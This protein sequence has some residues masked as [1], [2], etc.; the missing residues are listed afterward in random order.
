MGN[1]GD[2]APRITNRETSDKRIA[3]SGRKPFYDPASPV[4]FRSLQQMRYERIL[5]ANT[6]IHGR[7]TIE[8][9]IR[10]DSFPDIWQIG[11]DI[12]ENIA[13]FIGLAGQG[14]HPYPQRPFRPM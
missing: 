8:K 7:P 13:V 10:E 1:H 9:A 4:T 12:E 14:L 6:E 5:H 11:K 3:D 2:I